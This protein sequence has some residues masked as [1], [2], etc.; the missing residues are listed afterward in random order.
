VNLRAKLAADSRF[1]L[2]AFPGWERFVPGG[3]SAEVLV[4]DLA[5]HVEGL[6][7]TGPVRIVGYSL[8]AH[9]GYATAL[10]L[11]AKGRDIAGFCAIDASIR[12]HPLLETLL[13]LREG[14]LRSLYRFARLKIRNTAIRFS[15]RRPW[16]PS[17]YTAAQAEE[18]GGEPESVKA[19]IRW[20]FAA[21]PWIMSLDTNPTQLKAPCALV[22]TRPSAGDDRAWTARC[23]GIRIL[24]IP[25]THRTLLSAEHIDDARDAVIAAIREWR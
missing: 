9:L 2:M 3:F 22:R 12:S 13:L 8:G 1:E 25:G 21:N 17:H 5:A 18:F 4:R 7:P 16:D 19:L 6:V 14:E 24:G 15:R 20:L 11:Q 10:H 23:P